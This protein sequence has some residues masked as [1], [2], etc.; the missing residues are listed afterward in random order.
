MKNFLMKFFAVSNEVNE[1]TVMGVIFSIC[2]I[3]STFVNVGDAK[4][5]ILAGLVTVFFGLNLKKKD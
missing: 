2:L 3:V 1:N 4:Y 5:Y